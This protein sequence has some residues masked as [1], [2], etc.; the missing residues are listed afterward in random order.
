MG[1]D[2]LG[3]GPEGDCVFNADGFRSC[4]WK[5]PCGTCPSL[6]TCKTIRANNSEEAVVP[7]CECPPGYGMTATECKA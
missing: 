5:S 2:L 1:C 7:Y 4:K 6:A 3:C